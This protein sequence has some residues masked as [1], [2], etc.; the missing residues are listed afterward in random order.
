MN[1]IVNGEI[2]EISIDR[3]GTVMEVGELAV[4]AFLH[5]INIIVFLPTVYSIPR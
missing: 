3:N 4:A 2:S 5:L 1:C